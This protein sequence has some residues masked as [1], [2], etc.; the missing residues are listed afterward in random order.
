[1]TKTQL[2]ALAW[3]QKHGIPGTVDSFGRM[4]ARD[5]EVAHFLPATFLRLAFSAHI[6]MSKGMGGFVITD[7]GY[8]RLILAAR[9]DGNLRQQLG[10]SPTSSDVPPSRAPA[11]EQSQ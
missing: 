3:L 2:R 1:M 5:K 4:V 6:E 11:S 7:G 8:H 10:I 9:K